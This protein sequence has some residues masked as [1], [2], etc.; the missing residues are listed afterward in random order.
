MKNSIEIRQERAE[1]IENANTLLN[2]AKDESRDFTADEQVSYDGMMTNIDKLAKDIEVV[3]RQEKLNA[4]IASN[5]GSAPV[6]KTSDTKEAR[7]YSMFKAIKGM[8]NNNLD[9]V[10]KE[11]HE[12]AVNEARSQGVAI[13]GLGI[14]ASMLEQRAAVTQGSSAIAPTNILSYADALREASVFDKVGATMLT[15]LSANTT[16]PVAAK[17]SVNWE[18][19]TDATADGGANFSKVELSPVRCAAYVD[20]SKQLL[21]QND[22]VEQV[23]MRDLGRAVANKLDAAIFGS[24]NVTGA[25]TAIATSGSIGT[26]TESAFVAGS[27]VASD[28]VT[29]QGKLAEAGALSGNLAYVCSPELMGQIKSGAQVD[30]I[31]A[32][33]QGNLA[34][35][36]P[37]YFTN[38][39]GNS[40]GVSG[41]FLFGDFSRLFIGMFGGLDITVDPY[42]QAASGINRLVLNNY[43]DFGVADAGAGFVKATSLVA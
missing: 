41:D 23:I 34:V 20:I 9:G 10:E 43:V 12:Q 22:G 39:V 29:A 19:E 33:M 4:E 7:S 5:V 35:G 1:A 37:V 15:G 40:A 13:N 11:M 16:I 14:P 28:M 32:A 2:L 24:S 42:T 25:P 38:S 30:S 26:F 18:G 17:T 36:Y 21:L 3:E 8:I 31:L 6:Q 27:S